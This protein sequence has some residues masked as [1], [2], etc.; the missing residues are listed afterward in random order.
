MVEQTMDRSLVVVGSL[1]SPLN[2]DARLGRPAVL[3]L[4]PRRTRLD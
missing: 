2:Q 3:A 4:Q 1:M